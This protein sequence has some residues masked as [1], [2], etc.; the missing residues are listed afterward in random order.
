MFKSPVRKFCESR[1]IS[2]GMKD[3]FSAYLRTTYATKFAIDR[4]T[5]TVQL[6][7][8]K[9]TQEQLAEEWTFFVSDFKKY[10]T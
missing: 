2:E 9:M 1:G 10:L 4:D 5:D 8:G 3:A 7:V 6:I